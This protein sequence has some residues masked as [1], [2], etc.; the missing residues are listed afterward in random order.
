[1]IGFLG[2][3]ACCIHDGGMKGERVPQGECDSG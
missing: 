2:L 1:M 3:G